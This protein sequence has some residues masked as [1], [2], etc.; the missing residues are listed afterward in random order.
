MHDG[1]KGTAPVIGN[2][3][4]PLLPHP[5]PNSDFRPPGAVHC[6]LLATNIIIF[7]TPKMAN[8]WFNEECIGHSS[9]YIHS[10][11]GARCKVYYYGYW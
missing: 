4:N 8:R 9:V 7:N 1:S 11:G 2:R 3:A 6:M 10:P 5:I